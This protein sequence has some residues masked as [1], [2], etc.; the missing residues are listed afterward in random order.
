MLTKMQSYKYNKIIV[1]YFLLFVN[2]FSKTVYKACPSDT[3]I[4]RKSRYARISAFD[5]FLL[6]VATVAAGVSLRIE[7]KLEKARAHFLRVFLRRGNDAVSVRR[8]KQVDIDD[9]FK[10][11]RRAK[12]DDKSVVLRVEG[13][14]GRNGAD[15]ALHFIRHDRRLRDEQ[16]DILADR[17]HSV[18]LSFRTVCVRI[19]DFHGN[20]DRSLHARTACAVGQTV[21]LKA[22]HLPRGRDTAGT[23]K[24]ER[25]CRIGG[26]GIGDAEDDALAL[27]LL[28]AGVEN[29]LRLYTD[30]FTQPVQR[31]PVDGTG[32][33][34][35][36]KI[37]KKRHDRPPVCKNVRETAALAA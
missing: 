23:D 15:D 14:F 11:D 30:F 9:D 31:I 25:I 21:Y 2:T 8:Q 37:G 3:F 34:I 10:N 35:R 28:D 20:I 18:C 27:P 6:F 24:G 29:P 1:T 32:T 33:F 36:L 13:A 4:K 5:W 22:G 7:R 16:N 12:I 17:N 19:H 26:D